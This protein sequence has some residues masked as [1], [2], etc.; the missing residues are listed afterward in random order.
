MYKKPSFAARITNS[1]GKTLLG[2]TGIARILTAYKG[3]G[4]DASRMGRRL[5][6]WTAT[7]NTINTLLAEGGDTL[8]ARARQLCRENPYASNALEAFQ[9][10]AVGSGIKPSSLIKDA[11]IKRSV[12]KAW[13]KWTDE[14]DADGLTDFYGLQALAARASFEAGECFI[15]SIPCNPQ[16]GDPQSSVSVPYQIR[17][18]ESEM[19]DYSFH[20]TL[21]NGNFIRHGIEINPQGK[22]VNYHFWAQHPGETLIA[23]HTALRV[24]VPAS[25]ID[26]IYKPLRPGQLR[27]QPA[28]TPGM[29]RLYLLDQYDDAELDRK[30]V[31]AMFA[32][33]ITKPV[34]DPNEQSIM[35]TEQQ[36]GD[37]AIATLE[38]GTMQELLAGEDIKFSNPSEVGGS[39]EAFM[40]RQLLSFSAACGVPYTD[41]T[42][43][44]SKSNYSSSRESQV[45]N[46]RRMD[47]FQHM[48]LV[49]QMCRPIW[50]RWFQAAVLAQAIPIPL[51]KFLRDKQNYLDVK[52]IPP[53]WDWVDPW[54]DRKAEALAVENGWKSRSD[55][56]EAEGYDPEEVDARIAADRIR[57]QRLGLDFRSKDDKRIDS[58]GSGLNDP[59][60][61]ERLSA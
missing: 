48:V 2:K 41:I 26:H 43:D 50:Q 53:K 17:L 39:Y 35:D 10:A 40:W 8:R 9:S 49:F 55:V 20:Q 11:D 51:G 24:I 3:G 57:E 19:L 59:L 6:G 4:Y 60:A 56:I 33:F 47:Q 32:G 44:M 45:S 27:G 31:A 5:R 21:D 34:V 37:T 38:P 42:N 46:R 30:R 23:S 16:S 15:Q 7:R 12:M 18:L 29:V 13:C 25:E 28:L 54:K 52:W 61:N 22:R 58:T 14:C 36:I 1:L